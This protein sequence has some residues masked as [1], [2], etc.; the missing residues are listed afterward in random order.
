MRV[1]MATDGSRDA[2]TAMTSASRLLRKAELQA[3]VLCVAPQL[4]LKR[5]SGGTRRSGLHDTYTTRITKESERIVRRAQHTLH[6]E[7]LSAK[8]LVEVGS[9][10]DEIIRR[11][12]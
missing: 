9:P 5:G 7:G 10:A 12:L 2:A 11:A 1:L 6:H 3:D 8:T 4:T